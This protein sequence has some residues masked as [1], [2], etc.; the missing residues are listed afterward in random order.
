MAVWHVVLLKPRADLRADQ[1]RH[2][3]DV[4]RRAVTSIPS[5]RGVRF[6]RRVTHGAGYERN[7][8][9][10]GAFLAIIEFDNRD[11]LEAYLAHPTHAELGVAFGESLSAALVY[12]FEMLA[13]NSEELGATLARLIEDP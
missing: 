11:G 1:R 13:D 10:A 8:P 7:A 3:V 4:F 2:F 9:D 12:D 6:G 5:V